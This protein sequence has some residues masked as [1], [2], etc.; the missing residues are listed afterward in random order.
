MATAL[1]S[2]AVSLE[3]DGPLPLDS[4]QAL[5]GVIVRNDVTESELWGAVKYLQDG[6]A[7][8]GLIMPGTGLEHFMDLFLD[9]KDAEA[10]RVGGT[11]RTSSEQWTLAL[12][13]T[14]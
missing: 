6:A 5:A 3:L 8:I 9:A 12:D 14:S 1:A 7:E 11:P 4:G 13:F 10:G 2:P